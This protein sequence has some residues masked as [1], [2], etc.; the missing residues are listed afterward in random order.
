MH[1]VKNTCNYKDLRLRGTHWYIKYL[2]EKIYNDYNNVVQ[3][4]NFYQLSRIDAK[5]F[6]TF[7][8][9]TQKFSRD[10]LQFIILN[11]LFPEPMNPFFQNT[12][13]LYYDFWEF[14]T[15]ESFA[16]FLWNYNRLNQENWLKFNFVNCPK[17]VLLNL[18]SLDLSIAKIC[19][20]KISAGQSFCP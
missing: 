5:L 12:N 11:N 17:F 15:V 19:T 13:D 16:F 18:Q 4:W 1:D 2:T 7:Q 8:N 10:S 9:I 3:F 14:S 20:V 6:K